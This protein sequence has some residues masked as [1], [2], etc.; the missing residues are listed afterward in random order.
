M[1]T[2]LHIKDDLGIAQSLTWRYVL[3]LSLVATLSTAAWYSLEL[4]ISEQNGTAA[5]V[6]VSG[7]QRMLSQRTALFANLL[8]TAPNHERAAIRQKLTESVELMAVSHHGLL[9]GNPELGLPSTMSPAIKK[10]YYEGEQPLNQQVRTYIN[11]VRA[12]IATDNDKLAIDNPAL[13][14]ITLTAPTTLVSSLDK[15]VHQYQ[16]EGEASIKRLEEAETALWIV[17]LLLLALEAMLI[18][19]PFIKHIKV[20]VGKLR[21]ATDEI[22]QNQETLEERIRQRTSE[23]AN[24]S[25][26]LAESEQ[27]LSVLLNNTNIH[28][29]A[30]DGKVFTYTNRQW[31]DFTGQNPE[32]SLTIEKW[33]SVVHP[34]DLA[35]AQKIWQVDFEKKSG[36]DHY[37]RLK[38]HDGVYRDFYCRVTPIKDENGALL[39][40]QGHNLDITDRKQ[41]EDE[42]RQL[43]FYDALTTLPNRRLLK[44][45]LNQTMSLSKRSGRYCALMFLDLDN[46][47]PINDTYGHAF[48]DALLLEVAER[49]KSCVRQTDTVARFGGDEFVVLLGTLTTDKE[50]SVQQ[51]NRIAE[52][53][54]NALLAPYLLSLNTHDAKST[55]EHLCSASIGVVVFVNHNSNEEE[56]LKRADDAMYAAKAAGRNQIRLDSDSI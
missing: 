1:F 4:V 9:H 17:T 42:V 21:R 3:A 39:Y 19:H 35:E 40:L 14:Y 8:V 16:L 22:L 37:F 11:T 36:H 27:K 32:D 51:A 29:W 41:L 47:K 45:R 34:E 26:A 43:A 33:G 48:G 31:F 10:M 13:R 5:V 6:N 49:I 50:K 30:F 18:F 54:R 2:P 28:M 20:V 53:I 23:L 55:I 56:V 15:A 25:K 12:L 7:R 38:R 52:K 46:F 24:R 44:D